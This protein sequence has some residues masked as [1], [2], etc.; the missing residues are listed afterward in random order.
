MKSLLVTACALALLLAAA[1]HAAAGQGGVVKA[2]TAGTAKADPP[3]IVRDHRGDT[4]QLRESTRK[5][6]RQHTHL[7]DGSCVS[8]WSQIPGAVIRDHRA[9][10]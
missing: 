4:R 5:C 7:L 9:G 2:T 1:G 3:T 6:Y 8:T 10:K